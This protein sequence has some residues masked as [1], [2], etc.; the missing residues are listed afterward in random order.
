MSNPTTIGN[1]PK[2]A[3]SFPILFGASLGHLLNDLLQALLPAMYPVLQS[4]FSL[5]FAQIGILSFVYQ[6]TASLF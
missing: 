1:L 6:I 5:T 3:G 2:A 4:G